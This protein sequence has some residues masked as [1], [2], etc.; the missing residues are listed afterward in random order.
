MMSETHNFI[1]EENMSLKKRRKSL[2]VGLKATSF[3]TSCRKDYSTLAIDT[4]P[5]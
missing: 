3:S 5:S 1:L 4:L 2:H